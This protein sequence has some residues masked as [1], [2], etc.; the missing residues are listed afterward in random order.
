VNPKQFAVT[1]QAPTRPP[2]ADEQEFFDS[3]GVPAYAADNNTKLT[4]ED[5][6]VVFSNNKYNPY[7]D[8]N[9]SARIMMRQMDDE[10]VYPRFG[11]NVPMTQEQASQFG[12]DG[13]VDDIE[14]RRTMI[15]RVMSGDPS[16]MQPTDAQKLAAERLFAEALLSE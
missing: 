1:Q 6:A 4:A 10:G 8:V 15:A 5:D 2:T 7:L 16:A 13:Y 3:M 12:A 11:S 14:G 9:E